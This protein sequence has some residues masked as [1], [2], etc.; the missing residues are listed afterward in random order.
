LRESVTDAC[1]G[2]WPSVLMQLGISPTYLRNVHGPC[3]MCGGKDRW[4]F[5]DYQGTGS[6]WCNSCGRGNGMDLVMAWKSCSFVEAVKL[7]EGVIGMSRLAVRRDSEPNVSDQKNAMR[8]LWGKSL[9]LTGKDVASRYL[10]WRG[11][12]LQAWPSALRWVRSIPYWHD[13]DRLGDYPAMVARIVAPDER[14]ANLQRTYLEE[15]GRKADVPV[16]RKMMSGPVPYGGA[17]RLFGPAEEMGVAEGI[18]TALAA[19]IIHGV[20]VWATLSTANLLR[21]QPPPLCKKL[22]VFGDADEHFAGQAAANALA[23]RVCSG[24]NRIEAEVRMPPTGAAD[25]PWAATKRDWNDELTRKRGHGLRV[26][27]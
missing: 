15:P 17:V 2:R 21:F 6:Y 18:E 20:P 24:K 16:T 3:P 14:S 5:Q 12:A 8:A 10:L 4:R 22:I 23:H 26:V 1:K 7:I 19:S 9:E 27:K 13:K 11:L 25:H